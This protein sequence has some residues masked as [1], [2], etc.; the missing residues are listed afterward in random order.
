MSASIFDADYGDGGC[1]GCSSS[2][3]TRSALP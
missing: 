3:G 1:S 2:I